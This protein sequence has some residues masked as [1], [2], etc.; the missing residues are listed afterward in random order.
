M[1]K[2]W[3]ISPNDLEQNHR[4]LY[5]LTFEI[6]NQ[7]NYFDRDLIEYSRDYLLISCEDEYCGPLSCQHCIMQTRVF[8]FSSTRDLNRCS[9]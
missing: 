3:C 1:T 8:I 6:N 9:F 5:L 7:T 4:C 2:S